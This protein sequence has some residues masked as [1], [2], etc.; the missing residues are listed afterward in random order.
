MTYS[1]YPG[2]TLRTKAK[3]L[4]AFGR[5]ALEK[6]GVTL[7]EVEDWQCCGGAYTMAKDEIASKLSSVRAL[8]AAKEKGTDLVTLC[9]ACHNVLKQVNND[10][11]NDANIATKA[12]NYLQLDTPYNG[13]TKVLHYLEILRDVVGFEAVAKAVSENE[14]N[15][16]KG[17]KIG[18]YYG[19]LLLRPG[20]VMEM[21]NAENPVIMEN[22]IKVLGAEPVVYAMRNEC[23]GGY[24]TMEDKTLAEKKSSTVLE[25]AASN[26]AEY[27]ITACP[28]CL[29][30]LNKNG[31]LS[32]GEKLPVYYFT[33]LLAAALGN[34]DAV[35]ALENFAKTECG[36]CC[37]GGK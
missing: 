27:L 15:P 30:N 17:K 36:C 33:T 25:N 8:N 5:F 19:C 10:M 22:L 31:K 32:S 3:E 18:A 1:Y 26:G 28:L 12:N 11:K 34:A 29:Y 16:L 24:V 20:K 23:C 13:E 21:D 6:L 37:N 7:Q 2:C 35:K 4:D 9:S 14:N